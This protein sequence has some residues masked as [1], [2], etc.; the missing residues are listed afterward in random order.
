M[1]AAARRGGPSC[2][3][4]W[5]R[6]AMRCAMQCAMRFISS[7]GSCASVSILHPPPQKP[8]P[9]SC[10]PILRRRLAPAACVAQTA[11]QKTGQLFLVD[12]AG[13][14]KVRHA[15]AGR[16][17]SDAK[18]SFLPSFLPSFQPPTPTISTA[19]RQPPIANAALPIPGRQG[20]QDGRE[21]DDS[22][23]GQAHQQGAPRPPMMMLRRHCPPSALTARAPRANSRSAPWATS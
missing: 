17:C 2:S 11:T 8:S 19:N 22:G 1:C 13:S 14:E 7:A 15:P 5:H 12:L 18:P 6:C 21:G 16:S 10:V 3:E 23:R 9:A 20:G 4:V